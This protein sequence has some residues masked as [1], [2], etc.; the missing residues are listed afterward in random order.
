MDLHKL[1][2]ALLVA[3][4]AEDQL[5]ALVA[6]VGMTTEQIESR[7]VFLKDLENLLRKFFLKNATLSMFG[8]CVSDLGFCGADV[9][10]FANNLSDNPIDEKDQLKLLRDA[11]LQHKDH[12]TDLNPVAGAR[13][14]ILKAFAKKVGVEV[15][16]SFRSEIGV[17][18]SELIRLFVKGDPRVRKVVMLLRWW[19][20]VNNITANGRNP[21]GGFTNYAFTWLVLLHMMLLPEEDKIPSVYELQQG[22]EKEIIEGWSCGFR[23]DWSRESGGLLEP[24]DVAATFFKFFAELDFARWVLCPLS[25]TLVARGQFASPERLGKEFEVYKASVKAGREPMALRTPVCLQDPF[26]LNFNPARGATIS[27]LKH[28]I[29]KCKEASRV[30]VLWRTEHE[31]LGSLY[32]LISLSLGDTKARQL[33]NQHFDIPFSPWPAVPAPRRDIAS[34]DMAS[35]PMAHLFAKEAPED[36]SDEALVVFWTKT[37]TSAIKDVLAHCLF[38]DVWEATENQLKNEVIG[39]LKE[40]APRFVEEAQKQLAR[41]A[42]SLADKQKALVEV[43]G[44]LDELRKIFATQRMN[45]PELRKKQRE[46]F[47]LTQ[48]EK[49]LSTELDMNRKKIPKEEYEL[50]EYVL[51]SPSVGPMEPRETRAEKLFNEVE[52]ITS[53][54]ILG[55]LFCEVSYPS[56]L[57]RGIFSRRPAPGTRMMREQMAT[58]QMIYDLQEPPGFNFDVEPSRQAAAVIVK[59]DNP[60]CIKVYFAESSTHVGSGK[61]LDA[62]VPKRVIEAL[63]AYLEHA[64]VYVLEDEDAKAHMKG[65]EEVG[66]GGGENG[67]NE[68]VEE[69][70]DGDVEMTDNTN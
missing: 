60:T 14:P 46:Q 61:A 28:F 31:E 54:E 26:E 32:P 52:N 48:K 21:G 56:L 25:G 16:F 66:A 34:I 11:F 63:A 67:G 3:K 41:K 38:F 4:C 62:L 20:R 24:L 1:A 49:K 40:N 57:Q 45:E 23:R 2:T 51:G 35:C 44:R 43:R 64:V 6:I 8:S 69:N 68:A 18:N 39:V 13:V 22:C 50:A 9:D 7:Q 19:A 70:G 42:A 53:G 29:D 55:K 5:H 27:G 15:D 17:R 47:A 59:E 30:S 10:V 33:C 37:V 65:L 12:M 58:A 36:I